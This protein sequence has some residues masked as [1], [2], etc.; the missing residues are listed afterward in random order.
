[1]NVWLVFTS[2][3]LPRTSFREIHRTSACDEKLSATE[4]RA[5]SY[6][7]RWHYRSLL[8]TSFYSVVHES[9]REMGTRFAA[10]S[11]IT[12][13]VFSMLYSAKTRVCSTGVY[14]A[15]GDDFRLVINPCDDS[16]SYVRLGCLKDNPNSI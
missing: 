13:A 2:K 12:F 6:T 15:V 1:M 5:S 14:R 8:N 10:A 9:P 3:L 16:Y 4:F 7:R 11:S